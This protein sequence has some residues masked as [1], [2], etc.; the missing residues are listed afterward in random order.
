[1]RIP[2]A[3]EGVP[4]IGLSIVA[5]LALAEVS[6][7]AAAPVLLAAACFIFFFREPR[8]RPALGEGA[9]IA[10]ADGRVMRVDEVEEN[11]YFGRR[12][13]RVSVFMSLLDVHINYAPVSGTVDYMH[14]RRGSFRNAMR[15]I[16]S[17]VNE[18]NTI[19]IKSGAATMAVR[20]IAGM[21]ARRIVCRCGVG[22][23]VRAGDRIGIIKFSS[24]VDVLLPLDAGLLV[25][26][27]DRVRGG[28]TAIARLP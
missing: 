11:G 26:E 27:G 2:I 22:D 17:E 21:I 18:N 1:M 4:Y 6:A 16:A 12:V 23:A 28:E 20:Q 5:W 14:Y 9:V 13:R 8:R 15:Q 25:R 3:R 10:P 24:R 19:G 7:A